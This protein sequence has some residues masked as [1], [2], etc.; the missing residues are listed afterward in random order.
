MDKG[1]RKMIKN[2]RRLFISEGGECTPTWKAE[3]KEWIAD[4]KL[5]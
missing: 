1:V 4:P 2:R 3:K 5:F